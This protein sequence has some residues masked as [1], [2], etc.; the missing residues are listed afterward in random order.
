MKFLLFQERLD[1]SRIFLSTHPFFFFFSFFF[2]QN[3]FLVGSSTGH[4]SGFD[5]LP[6]LWWYSKQNWMTPRRCSD[7]TTWRYPGLFC[8]CLRVHIVCLFIYFSTVY[9]RIGYCPASYILGCLLR[10]QGED[11]AVLTTFQDISATS[12]ARHCYFAASFFINKG[13]YHFLDTKK[14]YCVDIQVFLH[15]TEDPFEANIETFLPFHIHRRENYNIWSNE[16]N[17][18]NSHGHWFPVLYQNTRGVCFPH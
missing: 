15:Q 3:D 8:K 1:T 18:G 9:D 2:C 6:L 5:H 10:R 14:V 17:V 7:W 12:V 13:S 16:D 11:P 4:H